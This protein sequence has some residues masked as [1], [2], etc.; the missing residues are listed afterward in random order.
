MLVKPDGINYFVYR[1]RVWKLLPSLV[2]TLA[3]LPGAKVAS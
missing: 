2:S 1:V 3:S